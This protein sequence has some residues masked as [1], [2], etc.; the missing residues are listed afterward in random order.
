MKNIKIKYEIYKEL[1]RLNGEIDRKIIK[2][3]SYVSEAKRHK[4]L[5]SMLKR[6]S[7]K[8]TLSSIMSILL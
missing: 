8:K 5:L 6:M 4:F 1:K 7:G 2:G 3:I